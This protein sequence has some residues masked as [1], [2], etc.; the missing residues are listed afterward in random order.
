M[1]DRLN[2]GASTIKK[3][4]DIVCNLL[5][6]KDK[7]FSRYINILSCQCLK[8][9]IACFENLTCIPNICEVV[10]G[11]HILLV[12]LPSKRVTLA[13]GDFFIRKKIPYFC[14]A[15]YVM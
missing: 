5:I 7:L 4:V 9:I 10:G 2:V 15:S 13:N 11:I 3:Y 6:D 1:V 12:D 8:D 14:V